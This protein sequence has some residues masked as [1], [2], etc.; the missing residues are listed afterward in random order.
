MK[1]V[2]EIITRSYNECIVETMCK[3]LSDHNDTGRPLASSTLMKEVFVSHNGPPSWAA[4]NIIEQSLNNYFGGKTWHFNA[5][6]RLQATSKTV[7]KLKNSSKSLP[8]Y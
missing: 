7:M 4:A 3:Y 8:F 6:N 2:A 5:T 1:F